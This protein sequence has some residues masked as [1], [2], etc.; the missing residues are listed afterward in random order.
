MATLITA[1]TKIWKLLILVGFVLLPCAEV[2]AETGNA[3]N[4]ISQL[5]RITFSQGGAAFLPG[6]VVSAVSQ[7]SISPIM[8]FV[9][10]NSMMNQCIKNTFPQYPRRRDPFPLAA[11]KFANGLCLIKKCFQQGM[12]LMILPQ[13]SGASRYGGQSGQQGGQQMGAVLAQAFTKKDDA[14]GGG[15]DPGIAQALLSAF[16]R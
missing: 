16:L 5:G 4:W 6:G 11:A 15:S 1:D 10:V 13:L 8:Q 14:C 7:G 12:L 2:K 3:Y 9:L